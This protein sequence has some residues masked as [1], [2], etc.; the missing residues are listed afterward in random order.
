[1]E[2]SSAGAP[3]TAGLLAAA[4]VVGLATFADYF[5]WLGRSQA[6]DFGRDSYQTWQ[7]IG[8]VLVLGVIAAMAGWR[9]RP[10]VAAIV[11]TIVMTVSWSIDA[12]TDPPQFNDGLWPIGALL[13]AVGTF[14]G[15]VL[16]AFA[17][18]ASTQGVRGRSRSPEPPGSDS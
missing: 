15:V 4:A 1:M 18:S 11:T 7:V 14:T 12:A 6:K 9:R 5:G 2:G 13:V 16:V 8:L 10:W 3:T 17:A